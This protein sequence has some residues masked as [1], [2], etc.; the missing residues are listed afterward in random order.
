[1]KQSAS[2][3]LPIL[4]SDTQG[5]ILA[6]LF[7]SPDGET[8]TTELASRLGVSSPTVMRELHRL[9]SAA[10]LNSRDV[11]RVKLYHPN[12]EHPLFPAI[13]Q[14]VEFTYGPQ[15]VLER[16]L[17]SVAGIDAAYIF[18][19][20]AARRAGIE[21]PP[22]GD[23]DVLIVGEPERRELYAALDRAQQELGREINATRL[24]PADWTDVSIN[25]FV[26]TVR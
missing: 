16:E 10:L 13:T 1:M 11:G 15:P 2:A 8:S 24:D 25:S 17:A 26:R 3:L 23:I 9:A 21:G 4:R 19:S 6:A 18:G 20:W 12:R 14:L 5:E 7:T 22:P